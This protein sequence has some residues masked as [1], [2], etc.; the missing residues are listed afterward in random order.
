MV[1]MGLLGEQ[2]KRAF[3]LGSY[4]TRRGLIFRWAKAQPT[5]RVLVFFTFYSSLVFSIQAP[6]KA[7]PDYLSEVAR[8]YAL[9]TPHNLTLLP[10]KGYQQTQDYTCAAA[11][12][13]SIMHYYGMLTAKQLNNKTEMKMTEDMG[14]SATIGTSSEQMVRWL[15][16]N[17]FD[18]KSGQHG[19]LDMIKSNLKQGHPILIDW[20][21]WGGHWAVVI[22]Y[23][24]G[25]K[26]EDDTIFLADP[27]AQFDG[28]NHMNGIILFNADRFAHMWF[29]SQHVK[30]RYIIAVPTKA[31]AHKE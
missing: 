31:A 10:I 29:D 2:N 14:T 5:L 20:I 11:S 4:L 26:P 3:K 8:F 6:S 27:S 21:D 24:K 13:M 18:V 23:N 16:H 25:E 19:T 7:T 15:L 9:K 1:Q 12:I 17:G 28:F 30:G 22:G